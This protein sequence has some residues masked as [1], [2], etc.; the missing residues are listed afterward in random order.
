MIEQINLIPEDIKQ[1]KSVKKKRSLIIIFLIFYV[2]GL[3]TIY[4]HE[5]GKINDT[6]YKIDEV[7]KKRAEVMSQ[8]IKYKEVIE[9]VTLLQKREADIKKRLDVIGSIL[10]TKMPW[11]EILKDITHVIP[12][13]IWFTSLSTYDLTKGAGK[14]MKFIGTAISTS[15]I[16]EFIFVMENYHF[17][18]NISLTYSQKKESPIKDLY[19][20]EVTAEVRVGEKR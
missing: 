6:L 13:G 3:G 16:A 8:N 18:K 9:R 17:F 5:N 2:I 7:E 1:L 11:S 4:F 12:D 15:N 20:F 14:G 10:D 19:D